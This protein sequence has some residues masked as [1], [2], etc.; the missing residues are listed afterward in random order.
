MAPIPR[1]PAFRGRSSERQAL[2]RLLDDARAG[3]SGVLVIRGE[4]GV[5]KTTL[6]QHAAE[7]A[8]G[9][10]VA[11]IAG[12]ESEME[13]PFAGLHQLCAPLLARLDSLPGPQQDALRVALGYASGEPPDRFLVGLAALTLLAE[14]AEERA[15]AVPRGRSAVARRRLGAGARASWRGRLLAEPIA[16]VFAV[17]EPTDDRR[18]PACRSCGSQGSATRTRSALLAT[19]VAGRLDEHVRERLIAETRGNPLALLELPRGMS[20]AELAGG[21]GRPGPGGPRGQLPAAAG[22]AARGHPAADAARGRRSRRRAAARVARGRAARHRPA[23]GDGGRRRR[24]VR[25]RRAGA[26]PAPVDALGGL[27]LGGAG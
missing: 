1:A 25:D 11:R 24:P 19:V 9:F 7:R 17:R 15:A 5:G 2:D 16:I 13:L 18:S 26:L 14:A 3:H 22:R 4:A 27:P 23:G 6:L 21:F 8:T 10:R 20:A 12:V